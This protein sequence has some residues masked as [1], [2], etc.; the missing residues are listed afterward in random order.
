MDEHQLKGIFYNCDDKYFPGHD[1]KEQNFFMAILE[2]VSKDDVEALLV[3]ESPE[4]TDMTH[5]SDPPK[6]E[7]VISLN[8][9]IVLSSPQTLKLIGYIK[10]RKVIILVDSGRTHNVI[11]HCISQETN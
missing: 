7:P 6:F 4:P 3:V 9:L 11:H 2:D 1:C 8:A 10:H 5:T